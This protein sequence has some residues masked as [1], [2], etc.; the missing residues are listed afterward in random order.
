MGSSG[1]F[2]ELSQSGVVAMR[3]SSVVNTDYDRLLELRKMIVVAE[4][5]WRKE[6]E[7]FTEREAARAKEKERDNA[8]L[9]KIGN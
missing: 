9:E 3:T 2:R 4:G 7:I 8:D 1:V 5:R 6:I